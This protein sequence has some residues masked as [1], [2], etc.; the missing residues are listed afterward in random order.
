[1]PYSMIELELPPEVL[2]RA[3]AVARASNRS[4]EAVIVESLALLF[5]TLP[6]A[7]IAPQA[8]N[9]YTDAQLWAVVH[10]HLAWPQD[11]RLRELVERGKQGAL[12]D[13]ER[14]ELDQLVAL[15]DRY[16]LLR[17]QALLLLKQRGYDVEQRLQLGA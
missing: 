9:A 2:D 3:Q 5:G 16:M 8:L 12:A 10:Q 13:A 11:S 17:S 1:M 7:A 14:A 4:V 15:V 6:D